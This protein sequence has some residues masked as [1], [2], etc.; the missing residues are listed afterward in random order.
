ME[1]KEGPHLVL[2]TSLSLIG[3]GVGG[4][5]QTVLQ[6]EN[7]YINLTNRSRTLF[8]SMVFQAPALYF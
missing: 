2:Q 5:V 7:R 8:V 3:R 1:Y 6:S 4:E